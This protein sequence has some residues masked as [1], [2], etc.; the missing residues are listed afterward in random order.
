M[1]A[2]SQNLT[3]D[4]YWHAIKFY[5]LATATTPILRDFTLNVYEPLFLL[6]SYFASL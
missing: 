3:G 1:C 4:L 6:K 5:V 2:H